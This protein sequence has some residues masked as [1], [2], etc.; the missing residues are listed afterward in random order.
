MMDKN[1]YIIRHC[2]AEGQ[3]KESQ[4]TEIG[5]T[6]ATELSSF[7]SDIKVDRIISS[8]FLRAIQTIKLF[9]EKR[10][11]NIEIDS[12]LSE[13]VLSSISFSDWLD[14]LNATFNNLELKYEGGESSKEAMSRIVEVVD[15]IVASDSENTII[16]THGNLMSLLLNHFDKNF[17]F[18]QWKSLSNPDVFLLRISQNDFQIKRLWKD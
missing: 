11:I 15:D 14:K 6:Q 3:S 10:D 17:G 1:I 13:R 7:L 9:A 4:L 16:V 5:F 18:E 2:K 8:P 12:R